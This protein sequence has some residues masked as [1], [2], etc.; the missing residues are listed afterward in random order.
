MYFRYV[1]ATVSTTA[2]HSRIPQRSSQTRMCEIESVYGDTIDSPF[3][4]RVRFLG[5]V[6]T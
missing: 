3:L 5:L 6:E 4:I 1:L 2:L